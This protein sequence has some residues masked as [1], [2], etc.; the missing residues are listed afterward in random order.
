MMFIEKK[1]PVKEKGGSLTNNVV[2]VATKQF[3]TPMRVTLGDGET[4]RS[5]KS[6]GSSNQQSPLVT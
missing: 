5:L 1:N 4:K 3:F 6:S 2:L